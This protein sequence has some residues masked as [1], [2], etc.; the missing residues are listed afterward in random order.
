ME[1]IEDIRTR[2]FVKKDHVTHTSSTDYPNNYFGFDDKFDWE[3]FNS[4]NLNL[5]VE[6]R[7]YYWVR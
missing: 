3:K 1:T 2:V 6:I 7:N 5:Y 4:V